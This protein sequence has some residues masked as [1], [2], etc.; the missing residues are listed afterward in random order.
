MYD[1]LFTEGT[2]SVGLLFRDRRSSFENGTK[3]NARCI[4]HILGSRVYQTIAS[5]RLGTGERNP[6]GEGT[7]QE[8]AHARS[9]GGS[10]A[11][12]GP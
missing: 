2:T 10:F 4:S 8:L 6:H 5:K 1:L 3:R 9:E 11:G 7:T 12:F